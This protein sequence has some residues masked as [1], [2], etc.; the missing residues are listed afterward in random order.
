VVLRHKG[1]LMIEFLMGSV[2]TV[3]RRKGPSVFER[4]GRR[5]KP[6]NDGFSLHRIVLL[7]TMKAFCYI[8]RVG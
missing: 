5:K 2:Y 3:G 7:F 6:P 8:I 1:A 4:S